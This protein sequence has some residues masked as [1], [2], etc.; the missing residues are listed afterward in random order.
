MNPYD[1]WP[2]LR[3]G[4]MGPGPAFLL[5]A[6]SAALA[7]LLTGVALRPLFRSFVAHD[8]EKIRERR[9]R[10]LKTAYLLAALS[11]GAYV[12][13]H[14]TVAQADRPLRMRHQL[15]EFAVILLGGY[16][17][18]E[19][20]LLF[21][22]SYIPRARGRQPLVP[23][24]QDL[25]RT[26]AIVGLFLLAVK[27][28]F[29]ATDLATLITTSAIL[30]I[31][32]GLALQESLSN[33]FAGVM[34][35]I[36]RPFKPG[37]WIQIDGQEGKVLDANWRS[38]R[39]LTR[40]DDVIYIPNSTLAKGNV[41][42][43]SDPEPL[44]LCRKKV[45]IEEDAPPNK[46]RSVLVS[47]MLRV[48]GVVSDPAPDVF[49]LDY[50]DSCVT[51]EL[52]FFA[53]DL[54][55]REQIESEVM[56]SVWY[57]LKR[58]GIALS[59][60]IRE[61]RIRRDRE[62]RKPEQLLDLLR[63]VDILRPLREEELLLLAGDLTHQLFARGEHI[64]LQGDQ[65]TTFYLIRSG[66][67]SVRVEGKDGVEVEVARLGPGSYFGEMSLLTGEPRSSTCSALEDAELLS[68]DRETFVVLLQENPSVAQSMSDILAARQ[69][70]TQEKL[71]SERE[72]LVRRRA[73]G[74][75]PGSQGILDKIRTIFKFKK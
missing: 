38:T 18:F 44:H 10:R 33:V 69:T 64:C 20:V 42:N 2:S 17:V 30:S 9:Y 61:V 35:T 70:A 43:F 27:Q 19:V 72:T 32:L 73:E 8:S 11:L 50:G 29:P 56:R 22:A 48:D 53:K 55:R 26:L 67:V 1:L 14:A 49:V 28:S 37:D 39:V 59:T 24:M 75:S 66:S 31:V 41:V 34:L 51:Y 68:L 23:I 62:E 25:V 7:W 57:H 60:L 63:R 5:A 12:F 74:P 52:R 54:P 46:V 45:D 21:F 6:V 13:F 65:G 15:S 58:E 36:D 16:A 4:T 47:M 71:S 3:E 40:D